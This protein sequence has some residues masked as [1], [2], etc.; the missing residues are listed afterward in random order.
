MDAGFITQDSAGGKLRRGMFLDTGD[1]TVVSRNQS[2]RTLQR[3]N[4]KFAVEWS[5]R[6]TGYEL[7][8]RNVIGNIP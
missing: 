3:Q 1:W 6:F 4:G 5:D 2:G 8:Q 7:V